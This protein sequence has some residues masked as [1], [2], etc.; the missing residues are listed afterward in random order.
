MDRKELEKQEAEVV[1]KLRKIR[2]EKGLSQME[3]SLQAGISQNMVAY[4]EA[5]KRT[6]TLTTMLKLCDALRI[7]PAVLFTYT[8]D[9]K[10]HVRNQ[11]HHMID[12]YIV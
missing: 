12:L 1:S 11:M 6:P 3:L 2:I 5:Q 8:D 10:E 7:S 4:I 9:E